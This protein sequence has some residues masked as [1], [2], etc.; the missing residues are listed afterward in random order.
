VL[1]YRLA[2]RRR[3]VSARFRFEVVRLLEISKKP[4]LNRVATQA[5]CLCDGGNTSTK[6]DKSAID[7]AGVEAGARI[8]VP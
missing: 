1:G 7:L 2:V 4:N 5:L 8:F 3:A 6:T